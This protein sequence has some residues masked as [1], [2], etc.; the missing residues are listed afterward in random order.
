MGSYRSDTNF[1]LV[2]DALLPLHPRVLAPAADVLPKGRFCERLPRSV[3]APRNVPPEGLLA[4]GTGDDSGV[5][6]SQRGHHIPRHLD[7]GKPAVLQC[8]LGVL[9]DDLIQVH[10]ANTSPGH[11][12][13]PF[14]WFMTQMTVL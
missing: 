12:R 8:P 14:S 6:D 3:Q 4:P 5:A 1:H 13:C 11:G 9:A 10:V 7:S 2:L